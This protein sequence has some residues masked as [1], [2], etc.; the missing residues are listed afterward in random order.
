MQTYDLAHGL[1]SEGIEVTVFCGFARQPTLLQESKNLWICRLPLLDIPPRVLWFQLRNVDYFKKNLGSFDVVHAQHSSGSVI[2]L[3]KKRIGRPWIVSFHDHQRR[4]LQTALSSGARDLSLGDML[5]Y[6]V[7][8]PL[9]ESMTRIEIR[10]ADHYIA[11]GFSGFEDYVRFSKMDVGKA[12]LIQNGVDLAKIQ[13]A[14]R[15]FGEV[16]SDSEQDS[17][18]TIFT[19]G[20]LYSSKGI[21]YLIRAMPRVVRDFP[22]VHLKIFGKGPLRSSLEALTSDLKL[23]RYVSLEGHVPYDRLMYEMSRCDLA[24]FPSLIE[25]GASLA[26]MEAMGFKKTIVAF[27]Y[28]FTTEIIDHLKT[29][30]LVRPKDVEEL[31]K[32]ISVL[33]GDKELREKLGEDACSKI[34]KD[35]NWNDVVKKYIQVYR[36]IVEARK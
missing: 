34:L 9:F 27:N 14:A 17:G 35:H 3:L 26:V 23:S 5:F 15:S 33:L 11:C 29:G 31:G 22:N 16:R 7:G 18:L 20:R 36:K 30:Y 12:T 1:S 10:Y 21:Q 13:S 32:A 24:V 25:V 8:Y 6:S 28:P 4:R 19:C 2:G